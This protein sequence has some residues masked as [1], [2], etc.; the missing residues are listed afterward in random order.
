[1]FSEGTEGFVIP[2]RDAERLTERLQYLADNP[3]ART[4]MGQKALQRVQI[5][6][7]WSEYGDSAMVIY[8]ALAAHA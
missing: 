5:L 2:I 7:G 3:E 1:L 4:S 6:G 8:K